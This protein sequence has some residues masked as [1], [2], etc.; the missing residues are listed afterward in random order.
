[1]NRIL[2][3]ASAL[4]SALALILAFPTF[5]QLKPPAL[6]IGIINSELLY[7]QYPEFKKMEEKLQKEAEGWASERENWAKDM[8]KQQFIVVEKENQLKA[9][10][11]TFTEKKK[12]QLQ[13][14]IDS[15]KMGLSERYNRQLM[16]EQERLQR[17]KSEL[18]GGV[19]EV[20]NKAI[21][22][23]GEAEDYDFIIDAANGS[24]IYAKNPEDISDKVLRR[25]KD[26]R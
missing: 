16:F 18:L 17:R 2:F 9:G 1:M 11:T 7:E 12:Q 3:S 8:E 4:A 25:L 6:K 10:Q 21:D 24:V 15:L 19:L 23:V 5:A 22:E 20:V 26:K 14:E 13:T